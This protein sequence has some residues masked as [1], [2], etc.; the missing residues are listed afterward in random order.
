MAILR[1]PDLPQMTGCSFLLFS[2]RVL[3]AY[4][5]N[6]LPYHKP[7]SPF[8]HLRLVL[9]GTCGPYVTRPRPP[10][11]YLGPRAHR[12]AV[13]VERKRF[14]L[15]AAVPWLIRTQR[16]LHTSKLKLSWRSKTEVSSCLPLP[17]SAWPWPRSPW[18]FAAMS[19]C[20]C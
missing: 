11:P 19:A 2:Y 8:Y 6:R 15:M 20:S 3:A 7:I 16:N 1:G 5:S 13:K 18:L 4:P 12:P 14:S 17:S 10:C 9:L